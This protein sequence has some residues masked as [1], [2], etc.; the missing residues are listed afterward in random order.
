MLSVQAHYDTFQML[1]V[2]SDFI[3]WLQNKKDKASQSQMFNL[4]DQI[5]RAVLLNGLYHV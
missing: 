2:K 3:A 4:I 5:L 1:K